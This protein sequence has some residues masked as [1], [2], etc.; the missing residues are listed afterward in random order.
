MHDLDEQEDIA[1]RAIERKYELKYAEVYKKRAALLK[2]DMTPDPAV[3]EKFEEMKTKMT[4]DPDYEGLETPIC[5]VK[6][7]QNSQKGVSGFFLRA[8]LAH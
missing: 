8:M 3:C 4:S 2:G 7:I 1:Y 6:E 5:D